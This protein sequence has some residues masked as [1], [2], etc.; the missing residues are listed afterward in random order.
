MERYFE[1][2]SFDQFKKDIADDK[3]LY[4]E[5]SLPK[6]ET[7]S[8][9]GYDFK[10]IMDFSIKPGETKKIP[11]GI[12]AY[13]K[14]DEFLMI[15]VRSS[16][17]FKYNVRLVNQVGIIDQDYYNNKDNEGHMWV[18]LQNEGDKE[19][20]VKKGEGFAQCLF[21]NYLTVSNEDEDYNERSSDY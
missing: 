17:G 15:I 12:K 13:M 14:E 4:E 16:T 6:R 19:Y 1:K 5:Y 7:K 2:I 18:K 20:V 10:A 11:T 3:E 21:A 9:A 8:A